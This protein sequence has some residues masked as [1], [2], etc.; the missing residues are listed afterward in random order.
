MVHA[1]QIE[2]QKLKK[3]NREVKRARTGNGNFSNAKSNG[4]RRQNFK[5]MFPNQGSSSA[6]PMV[7]KDRVSNPKP[8]GG[9]NDGYSKI[10]PTCAKCGKKHDEKCL[11]GLGVCYGFGKSGH[12]LRNCPTHSA[13]GKE[14]K[15]TPPSGSN[16]NTQKQIHF[17]ALRSREDQE[18]SPDV[19][20]GPGFQVV[21]FQFPN[22][23][24]LEW[25]WGNSIPRG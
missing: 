24:I 18:I 17:Y 14:D 25:K 5:Q 8:Q 12:Q 9:N 22:E 13:K 21:K 10:K 6:S 19:V 4:Q 23:P 20:T 3:M 15:Q 11:A 1:E 16:S 7:N 2:K